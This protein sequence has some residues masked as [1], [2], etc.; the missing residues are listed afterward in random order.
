L[1]VVQVGTVNGDVHVHEAH[2]SHP[3]DDS[4]WLRAWWD[5]AADT[6]AVIE[7]RHLSSPDDSCLD[8]FLIVRTEASYHDAAVHSAATI[9]DH[10]GV[11][12]RHASTVPITDDT[13]IRE[14]LE[15]F[16]PHH[17]G[18][19]EIRKRLMV[20]RPSRGDAHQPWLTAVTPFRYGGR[21]WDP[22][23]SELIGL[24]FRVLLSVGLRPYRVGPGL[25]AHL[26]ARATELARL[27]SQGP[28]PTAGWTVP[29]PP[30]QFAAQAHP[31]FSEAIRRYT[32]RA[33][34]IRISLAAEGPIPA[35]LAELVAETITTREPNGG[36]AAASPAVVRPGPADAST[37]WRNITSLN[38]DPLAGYTQGAPQE[39]IGQLE[40]ILGYIVDIDEAA[41]AFRLP[42]ELSGR[43]S[44]FRPLVSVRPWRC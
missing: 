35:M 31:L 23:W 42:Y 29:R 43:P 21:S 7:V 16:V 11:V 15:P 3:P 17:D 37:A 26:V 36:F 30:D 6:G 39:A 12:P 10:L 14:I 38:L 8:G 24:P 28:P 1:N 34:L 27:A 22:L 40:Q 25:R 20:A 41:A 33:F 9:R 44:L 2:S 4:A 5:A 13:Q 32:D 18:L 19:L